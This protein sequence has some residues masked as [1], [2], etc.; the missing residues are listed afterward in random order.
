MKC[1]VIAARRG[2]AS[3]T[4]GYRGVSF[5]GIRF[6]DG[7]RWRQ[8]AFLFCPP[9]LE[10][11]DRSRRVLKAVLRIAGI[12]GPQIVGLREADAEMFRQ[13]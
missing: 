9:A 3:A 6:F 13:R 12:A 1:R 4:V 2:P 7:S 5:G 10:P 11:P 8:A